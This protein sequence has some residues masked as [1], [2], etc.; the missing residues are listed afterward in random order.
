[1]IGVDRAAEA[2]F[3]I[4]K[5]HDP[6]HEFESFLLIFRRGP[7]HATRHRIVTAV[8]FTT[9][10]EGCD[11]NVST[12]WMLR[13]FQHIASCT[14]QR[15]RWE[16]QHLSPAERLFATLGITVTSTQNRVAGRSFLPSSP[17][18]DEDRTVSSSLLG[19]G[20]ARR[21]VSEGSARISSIL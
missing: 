16:G 19:K 10:E 5:P 1:M 15:R 13:V 8:H 20:D 18:R 14:H 11:T 21:T 12:R 7:C 4:Y 17:C 9:L 3:S 6:S 2:A